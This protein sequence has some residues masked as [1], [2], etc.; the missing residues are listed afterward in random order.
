MKLLLTEILKMETRLPLH[1]IEIDEELLK[2]IRTY[3]IKEP[4][5]IRIRKDN[6]LV[7]WDGLNRL[8]IA[9]RLNLETVPVIFM[10]M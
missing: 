2:D 1:L 6:S 8:A 9:A 3:G 4:I 5:E 7:V 10:R